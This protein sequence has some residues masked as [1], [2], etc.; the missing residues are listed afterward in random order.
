MTTRADK[1]QQPRQQT[2][3]R[4]TAE[5]QSGVQHIARL[6]DNRPDT[7]AQ[8]QVQH[9]VNQSPLIRRAAETQS[10]VRNSPHMTA[11]QERGQS[12]YGQ[13]APIGPQGGAVAPDLHRA[14]DRAKGGGRRLDST[15]AGTMGGALGADF[16]RVRVHTDYRADQLNHS[17]SAKAFTLG[18]DL[19]FSSGAYNPYTPGGRRL[20]AHELT[21]VAQQSG[22]AGTVQTKLTVGAVGDRYEQEADRV[23]EQVARG[24]EMGLWGRERTNEQNENLSQLTHQAQPGSHPFVPTQIQ[25]PPSIQRQIGPGARPGQL[26]EQT[27]GIR[28]FQI[29]AAEENERMGE[30]MYLVKSPGEPFLVPASNRMFKLLSNESPETT[31]DK[32][33]DASPTMDTV[34]QKAG[35]APVPSDKAIAKAFQESTF[36]YG[37]VGGENA[38]KTFINELVGN[39]KKAN[40]NYN[41]AYYWAGDR[42]KSYLTDRGTTDNTNAQMMDLYYGEEGTSVHKLRNPVIGQYVHKKMGYKGE[43]DHEK[44]G[45]DAYRETYATTITAEGWKW[46]NEEWGSKGESSAKWHHPDT[47]AALTGTMEISR[48]IRDGIFNYGGTL[49]FDG[50]NVVHSSNFVEGTYQGDTNKEA[51]AL[52]PYFAAFPGYSRVPFGQGVLI[53]HWGGKETVPT[54]ALFLSNWNLLVPKRLA[55][56]GE[57]IV[58]PQTLKNAK[59]QLDKD[60]IFWKFPDG[61]APL[62]D[63]E[64]ILS[65]FKNYAI[66]ARNKKRADTNDLFLNEL[67]SYDIS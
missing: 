55:K 10:A 15:L 29:L 23:A 56:R 32:T 22:S 30:W 17:L 49:V 50:K 7:I 6:A 43:Y 36:Y 5:S 2:A 44:S 42:A 16:S 63:K 46:P 48:V 39:A 9:M 57:D 53:F 14:I 38:N 41:S 34:S 62:S 27:S 66:R 11:Q 59:I 28:P 24:T 3:A 47:G 51:R 65:R 64:I 37:T 58:G 52:F 67:K 45:R 26:V 21:H 8:R 19:F 60:S 25:G 1:T 12:L 31:E 4:E 35:S 20:L 13:A 61:H 40:P 33:A 54:K 18:N